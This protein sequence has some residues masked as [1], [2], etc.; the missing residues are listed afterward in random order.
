MTDHEAAAIV[1][2]VAH[3]ALRRARGDRG[4]AQEIVAVAV[5]AQQ[6]HVKAA[7][8]RVAALRALRDAARKSGAP[9]VKLDLELLL[10]GRVSH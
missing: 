6:P 3:E 1:R 7:F 4:T 2:Y 5:K 9:M 8:A 10:D